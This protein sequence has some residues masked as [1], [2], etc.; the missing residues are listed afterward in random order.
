MKG[1]KLLIWGLGVVLLLAVV[2]ASIE[3][4]PAVL[5]DIGNGRLEQL[6]SD[7]A[8]IVD[9]RTPAEYAAGHIPGARNVPVEQIQA[10]AESWSKDRA[11]V[12]YC[13]TGARSANAAQWLAANGFRAVYNLKDGIVAWDGETTRDDSG[14]VAADVP[15]SAAGLPVMY[16]FF[17]SG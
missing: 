9:V 4:A 16:E 12:V 5:E 10:T 7:G 13:A 6:A 8:L 11:V 1:P 2:L 15:R 3:P 17:S 14:T